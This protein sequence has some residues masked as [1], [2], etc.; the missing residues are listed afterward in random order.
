MKKT[1]G[2]KLLSLLMVFAMLLSLFPAALA[3]DMDVG[4]EEA[5]F[6]DSVIGEEPEE[7][8]LFPEEEEEEVLFS[9]DF[10]EELPEE[11][12]ESVGEPEDALQ[13]VEEPEAGTEP[14]T[15]EDLTTE[16]ENPEETLPETQEPDSAEPAEEPVE[17]ETDGVPAD[18]AETG[19]V[20]AE[21]EE[22]DPAAES[23]ETTEESAEG[24]EPSEEEAEE[25]SEEEEESPVLVT[26]VF[27]SEQEIALAVYAADGTE[28]SPAS[29][30]EANGIEG[31][32]EA[33]EMAAGAAEAA[34]DMADALADAA[35]V[36]LAAAEVAGA[37]AFS[38]TYLLEPGIYTYTAS[39]EGYR[40]AENIPFA[41]EETSEILTVSVTL[42]EVLPYG[43][44][45]MPEGYELSSEELSAK[46]ALSENNVLATL[47]GM[48]P[49]VNYIEGQV[50]FATDS[51]E[52]AQMV[53]D[54]YSAELDYEF[55]VAILTLNT[56]TT[57]EAV[58]AAA[59]MELPLP[60]VEPNY[61]GE[62]EPDVVDFR[63]PSEMYTASGELVPTLQNWKSWYDSSSNPDPYLR[64][65]TASS[66]QYMHDVVNTYE[67]WGIT[68]GAGVSVAVID[69]GV[70]S[71]EDLTNVQYYNIG[72]GTA[73]NVGHGTHVAGIIGARV[74]NGLGGAGI[75]PEAKIVAICVAD[76]SAN[77][78]PTVANRIK[79]I[80]AVR[81][82]RLASIINMSLG[83]YGYSQSE[84]NAILNAVNSGITIVA[85]M[86]NE[87][88]N[89]KQ[90]PAAYNI[91]GIIAVGACTEA[92]VRSAYSNYGKWED[93]L[94]PGSAIMSTVPGGYEIMGGTSMASPV[95]AGVCALYMSI[96][97][98]PGPAAMEAVIKAAKTNGVI[99]ASK[100][101]AKD[102]SAAS[103]SFSLK[104]GKVPYNS[105]LYIS[106]GRLED[107]IVYTLNGKAPSIKDGQVVV[108]NVYTGAIRITEANGFKVGERIT[109][110]GA[111]VNGMGV[112]G[113][114]ASASFTVDYAAATGVTISGAPTSSARLQPGKSVTLTAKV[115]PVQAE[116]KVTWSI[117]GRSGCPGATI[118]EKTGALKA[119]PN[120]YGYVTVRATTSNG[121]YSSVT[122]Y[123]GNTSP[124]KKIQ[125]NTDQV[126][127]NYSIYITGSITL[128]ANAYSETGARLSGATFSWS[129]SNLKVATVSA[130]GQVTAVGKGK[131]V[132]TCKATDGSNVT[133]KCNV[134]VRQVAESIT[135]TGQRNIA[136][137]KSAAYKAS[138]L[139]ANVDIKTVSWSVSGVSGVSITSKGKLTVPS[140][141]TSGTV[142][143]KASA[144]DG[145]GRSGTISVVIKS[146]VTAVRI[147]K[148]DGSFYGGGYTFNKDGS[149]KEAVLYTVEAA[150]WDGSSSQKSWHDT[151]VTLSAS[152]S[153]ASGT[154]MSWTSSNEK[155]VRMSGSRAIAVAPGTAK[156]TC[157]AMDGSNKKATV[158]IKVVNPASGITVSSASK[159][160]SDTTKYLVVGKSVANKAILG[161]AFGKPTIT[162]VEWS[163]SVHAE[164][165][166]GNRR[167]W[168]EQEIINNKWVKI[169]NS[170]ALSAKNNKTLMYYAGNYNITVYAV[171]ETTDNTQLSGEVAYLLR[172]PISQ[173]AVINSSNYA[174]SSSTIY[175]SEGTTYWWNIGWR[176]ATSKYNLGVDFTA[177]SSNP[178]IAAAYTEGSVLYV[179]PNKRGTITV[180]VKSTD[181]SNKSCSFK[182][183]IR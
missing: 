93:V 35:E 136:P 95:V 8:A 42:D 110:K 126:M 34:E 165:F 160:T 173:I 167:Q 81:Q 84:Y 48:I 60:A 49:D 58:T 130:S 108:G 2:K 24:E 129:S 137:G 115:N 151:Y 1:D 10:V 59:D 19:E 63:M 119:G 62:I 52:Y 43:F 91:P 174:I 17:G 83:G 175:Y 128:S 37:P 77:N 107:T 135:V 145:S 154:T 11:I 156:I 88:T 61:I 176:A 12:P 181:G 140:W 4:A 142:T 150:Y 152:T 70:A 55:G 23:G 51:A 15:E 46:D 123:I 28:V 86:G 38:E 146:A 100:L 29:A 75:A 3:E 148:N 178:D 168:L 39:A 131:T 157:T 153:G 99:D 65:P 80:N 71:H 31:A 36:A 183:T 7:D 134:T 159:V 76:S 92:K 122:V 54:A 85:A 79:A 158:S 96:Y 78:S 161:D 171:A 127:L 18:D 57:L 98:N 41:V 155:V 66:Y 101:F 56:A 172:T 87:A 67:A 116:Q 6:A 68:K 104:N 164:D 138:I 162:K 64:D 182:V 163:Y 105:S 117:T 40:T 21:G 120:D 89:S 109:I 69:S 53:A 177:T 22:T 113:K 179:T 94:A 90:Y 149:L 74:S 121:K 82:N 9:E 143:V 30:M 25:A 102:T 166:N 50:I 72:A 132:I 27:T 144:T 169:S 97:G 139:P 124:V 114:V 73:D 14:E 32:P 16:G 111:N 45:G 20:P 33:A 13:P 44:K 141:V 170:G 133:A 147:M 103:I 112:M 26:V 118:N 47:A 125:L 5:V 180:K 106:G